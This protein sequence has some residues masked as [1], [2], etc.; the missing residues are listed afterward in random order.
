[1]ALSVSLKTPHYRYG[2]HPPARRHHALC[3]AGRSALTFV[4]NE[5]PLPG[6]ALIA[7]ASGSALTTLFALSAP[8]WT[9]DMSD[10]PL[11][12]SFAYTEVRA[13][14]CLVALPSGQ[15]CGECTHVEGVG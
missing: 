5:P 10:Y 13:A 4:T 9:D 6:R 1:V 3:C 12:Y 7:P 11:V 2:Y 15:D 14:R 8:D